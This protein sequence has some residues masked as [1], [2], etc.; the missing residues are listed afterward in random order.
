MYMCLPHDFSHIYF[1][2]DYEYIVYCTS[3]YFGESYDPRTGESI[4]IFP[5][6]DTRMKDGMI[7]G[8]SGTAHW[9]TGMCS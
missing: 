9:H 6:E 4:G 2:Y 3:Q 7:D 1:F 8:G 5:R